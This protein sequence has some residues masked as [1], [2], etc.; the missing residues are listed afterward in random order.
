[1]HLILFSPAITATKISSVRVIFIA[2]DQNLK[3]IQNVLNLALHV[4]RNFDL[5]TV[6]YQCCDEKVYQTMVHKILR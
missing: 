4:R 5:L 3:K 2:K 6:E 1:M